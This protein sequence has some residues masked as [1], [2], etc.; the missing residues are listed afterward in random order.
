MVCCSRWVRA[1]NRG[2]CI[3]DNK[4][5]LW[6]R[7]LIAKRPTPGIFHH[8]HV[9]THAE[10]RE[11]HRLRHRQILPR[12]HMTS[13]P[14]C[15]VCCYGVPLKMASI[16]ASRGSSPLMTTLRRGHPW[17]AYTGPCPK[18]PRILCSLLFQ[19]YVSDGHWQTLIGWLA[20]IWR[21]H[22]T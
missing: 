9:E 21:N 22:L 1:R 6:P 10:Q 16:L 17:V 11:L 15:I 14:S 8:G 19:T 3:L 13:C 12:A 20:K 7:F 4:K 5:D 18:S 2:Q